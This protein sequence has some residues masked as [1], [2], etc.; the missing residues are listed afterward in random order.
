MSSSNSTLGDSAALL[1]RIADALDRLAPPAR[2]R[3]DF[4]AADAFVWHAD[5]D[6]LAV[7]L[8]DQGEVA[9]IGEEDR[10]ADHVAPARAGGA[11]RRAIRICSR[12][13]LNARTVTP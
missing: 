9:Q 11:R 3:A 4:S 12:E 6:A 8:V 1:A 2:P 5:P 13:I 10:G 7:E